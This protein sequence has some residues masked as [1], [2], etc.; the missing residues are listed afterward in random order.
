MEQYSRSAVIKVKLEL[1]IRNPV[2]LGHIFTQPVVIA[3]S[4]R[5]TT[6]VLSAAHRLTGPR[7]ASASGRRPYHRNSL[8][9]G[10]GALDSTSV[11]MTEYSRQ[12][13]RTMPTATS[14]R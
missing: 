13:L 1:T 14:G 9:V 3:V 11:Q 6:P 4:P 12:H 5:S 8:L 7:Q 10:A 2:T